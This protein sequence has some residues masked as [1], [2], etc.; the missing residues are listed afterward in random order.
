MRTRVA[1]RLE[2]ILEALRAHLPGLRERYAVKSLGVFGSC[3]R[4]E[5]RR[6]SDVDVLVEFERA[7]TLF[8]FMDLQDE[9]SALLGVKVDLVMKSALRPAIG[10]RVL[11]EVVPV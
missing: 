2:G 1:P 4:G 3:V 8:T 6:S 9:L 5:Q 7:P 10:K 11:E